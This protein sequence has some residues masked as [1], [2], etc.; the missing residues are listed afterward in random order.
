MYFVLRPRLKKTQEYDFKIEEQNK[1][2]AEDKRKL[3][4][5]IRDL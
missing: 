1:L 4:D 2:L 5:R 3:E